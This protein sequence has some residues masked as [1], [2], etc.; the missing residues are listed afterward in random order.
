M[1][2][3]KLICIEFNLFGAMFTEANNEVRMDNR[4][5]FDRCAVIRIRTVIGTIA[6][7]VYQDFAGLGTVALADDA[8]IFQLVYDARGAAVAEP[9]A[10]LEQWDADF[11]FAANDFDALLDDFLVFINA[12][13]DVGVG[14][15]LDSCLW[16]SAS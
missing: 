15:R 11:L 9:Q 14:R 13:L 3:T 2:V 16:I 5:V 7:E 4:R 12:A 10:A 8:A 6:V 1:P